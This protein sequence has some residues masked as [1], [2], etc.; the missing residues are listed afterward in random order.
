MRAVAQRVRSA[1]VEV[2][3][4]LVSS[5]GEGLLVYLGAGREDTERDVEYVSEK[6]ANL[7]VFEDDSGS[8]NRSVLDVHGEALVVSQFTLY[9]DVRRGRRPS[10]TET[11]EP[12]DAERLY[13]SCIARLSAHGVP[14]RAGRFRAMMAVFSENWGPVTILLDSRKAF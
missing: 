7:R 10:F 8:M 4:A 11:A 9:G 13:E 3:G 12:E 1:R 6:L 14:T 5:I 2:D